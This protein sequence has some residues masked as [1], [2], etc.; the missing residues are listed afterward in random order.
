VDEPYAPPPDTDVTAHNIIGK[1]PI[2]DVFSQEAA[3]WRQ[4]IQISLGPDLSTAGADVLN[5]A[6]D[7]VNFNNISILMGHSNMR[8]KPQIKLLIK[9]WEPNPTPIATAPPRSVRIVRGKGLKHYPLFRLFL[10]SKKLTNNHHSDKKCGL[11]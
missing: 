9:L 2:N 11:L 1:G 8:T 4:D 5:S 6:D 10:L 3:V 7:V